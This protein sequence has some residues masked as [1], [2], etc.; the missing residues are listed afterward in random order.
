MKIIRPFAL[1]IACTFILRCVSNPTQ[2]AG[3]SE[4]ERIGTFGGTLCP[5][6]GQHPR[7]A[8]KRQSFLFD[9]DANRIQTDYVFTNKGS[10]RQ[11]TFCVPQYW[12]VDDYAPKNQPPLL[13]EWHL[14]VWV[15]GKRV[16]LTHKM[17]HRGKPGFESR[18]LPLGS[19]PNALWIAHMTLRKGQSR[20]IRV[21]FIS[22]SAGHESLL[23]MLYFPRMGWSGAAVTTY[24]EVSS[25]NYP[26][27]GMEVRLFR[28]GWGQDYKTIPVRSNS[29]HWF[30]KWHHWKPTGFLMA[31][32]DN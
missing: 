31:I 14:R 15:D 16:H 7:V 26:L 21:S 8:L 3:T 13:E 5:L 9:V 27:E 19:S 1:L 12:T 30:Y 20:H 17:L 25:K 28:Y 23:W 29:H 22:S 24:L 2:A 10:A 11:I 4:V 6:P 32:V 18:S